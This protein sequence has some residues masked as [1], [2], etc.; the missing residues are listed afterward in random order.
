MVPEC[1]KRV[2]DGGP[3]GGGAIDVRKMLAYVWGVCAC[4]SH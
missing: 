4:G 1:V 3:D 2:W